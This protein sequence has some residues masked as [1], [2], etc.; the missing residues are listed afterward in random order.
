MRPSPH[1]GLI[2]HGDPQI[3]VWRRRPS[4]TNRLRT[5]NT[6]TS[7]FRKRQQAIHWHAGMP[8]EE[9]STSVSYRVVIAALMISKSARFRIRLATRSSGEA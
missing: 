3:A 6:G 1:A 8:S 7:L 5:D 4:A 9:R 2:R